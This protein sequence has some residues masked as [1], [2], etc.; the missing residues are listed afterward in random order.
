MASVYLLA[1][2]SNQE[3]SQQLLQV[4]KMVL[5]HL[6]NRTKKES[7]S[8]LSHAI[9]ATAFILQFRNYKYQLCLH[10]ANS[11]HLL[12]FPLIQKP[13]HKLPFFFSFFSFFFFLSRACSLSSHLRRVQKT[14]FLMDVQRHR[15]CI[16]N[17]TFSKKICKK[18]Y[19]TITADIRFRAAQQ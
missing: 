8:H 3:K 17:F 15:V 12:Q 5:L 2:S 9:S 11:I 18:S 6:R 16:L 14:A 13:K 1:V 4:G 19:R 7:T 10:Q